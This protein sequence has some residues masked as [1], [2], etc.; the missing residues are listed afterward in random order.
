[1]MDRLVLIVSAAVSCFIIVHIL[2]QYLNDRFIRVYKNRS[3]YIISEFILVVVMTFVNLVGNPKLNLITWI[4]LVGFIAVVLYSDLKANLLRRVLE[5]EVLLVVMTIFEGLAALIIDFMLNILDINIVN[6]TMRECIEIMFSKILIIFAYYMIANRFFIKN[7]SVNKTLYA[8]NFIVF[9][10]S[11]F[12]MLIIAE[13]FQQG[14]TN[15][16]LIINMGCIILAVLFLLH[17]IKIANEKNILEYEY[18]MLEKQTDIQYKY[19]LEQ[20]KKYNKTVQ[21]L[22]DVNKHITTIEQ[23]YANGNIENANEYT[24]KIVETLKPLIPTRY[25][26]NP[27]LDILLTDKKILANEKIIDFDIKIDNIDI[28]FVDSVD[29]ITIFGNL[30]DNAIEACEYIDTQ[31]K[32]I[33][34]LEQHREMLVIRIKNTYK[35]IKWKNGVPISEKG[36]ERGIGLNNVKRCIEKYDGTINFKEKDNY[37]VVDIF[38]NP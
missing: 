26:G 15:L 1:M 28:N 9:V 33:L 30:L 6:M 37:F 25:I 18:K 38:L 35:D 2:F 5:C 17:F 8:I 32:I 19:Y 20:E 34:E 29:L 10:Y 14:E 13:A 4:C 7:I 31:R 3:I 27:I 23:L 22:H 11:F 16:Y 36:K 12:N 24:R 21:I